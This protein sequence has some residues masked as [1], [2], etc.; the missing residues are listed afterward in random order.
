MYACWSD[1]YYKHPVSLTG[2]QM[3]TGTSGHKRRE[4][5]WVAERLIASQR[6][7]APWRI[8]LRQFRAAD[9]WNRFYRWRWGNRMWGCELESSG[10]GQD[11]VLV[12][13]AAMNLRAPY[14]AS[15][16][17]LSWPTNS[18]SWR[19]EVYRFTTHSIHFGGYYSTV[20]KWT[21]TEGSLWKRMFKC[22]TEHK[23]FFCKISGSHDSVYED[24]SLLV[25]KAV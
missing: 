24:G 17:L 25:Y 3:F 12:T 6:H 4:N 22:L 20:S 10:L 15:N 11:P 23:S 18:F 1:F 14:K 2:R 8:S 7:C 5:C 16:F 21:G 19:T 13:V 9:R